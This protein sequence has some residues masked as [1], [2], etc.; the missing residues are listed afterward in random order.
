MLNYET[1][2]RMIDDSIQKKRIGATDQR[3]D[4]PDYH[5]IVGEISGLN[6]VKNLIIT[7]HSKEED[8]EDD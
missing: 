6:E 2:I 8:L 4:T 1:I 3:L 7:V 5:H